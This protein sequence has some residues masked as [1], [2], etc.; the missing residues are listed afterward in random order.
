MLCR[1]LLNHVE[2]YVTKKAN[3]DGNDKNASKQKA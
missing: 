1:D 3:H 2:Q